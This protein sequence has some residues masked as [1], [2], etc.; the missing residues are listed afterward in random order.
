MDDNASDTEKS[1]GGTFDSLTK[2]MNYDIDEVNKA[3]DETHD[4]ICGKGGYLDD[5]QS[6]T[7]KTLEDAGDNYDTF[8]DKSL[9]NTKNS[10]DDINEK[11][12]D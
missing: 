11:T 10:L 2:T 12:T 8:V 7:K 9:E 4:D 6:I 5:F 1:V 3:V